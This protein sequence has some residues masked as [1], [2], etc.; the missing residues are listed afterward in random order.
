MVSIK[1]YRFIS[2][3]GGP[4]ECLPQHKT[5][6]FSFP[7]SI[8][9]K[10]CMDPISFPSEDDFTEILQKKQVVDCSAIVRDNLQ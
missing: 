10:C 4:L 2:R 1:V 7:I 3:Q 6:S 9:Q 5:F 8:Y